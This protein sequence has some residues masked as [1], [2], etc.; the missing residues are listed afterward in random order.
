MERLSPGLTPQDFFEVYKLLVKAELLE[1][2]TLIS[3]SE[4]LERF[5]HDLMIFLNEST[6]YQMKGNDS[7]FPEACVE[8]CNTIVNNTPQLMVEFIDLK[9]I[10]EKVQSRAGGGSHQRVSSGL[11]NIKATSEGQLCGMNVF[12]ERMPEAA[13]LCGDINERIQLRVN[14]ERY[15]QNQ[16]AA[17]IR[18][19]NN[20]Q[21][22]IIAWFQ[23]GTENCGNQ[24]QQNP[25]EKGLRRAWLAINY[26]QSK[27]YAI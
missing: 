19:L 6:E 18:I 15:F 25:K 9:D 14:H 1:N 12:V 27:T 7:M 3:G 20:F 17:M 24:P 2:T 21:R 10:Y 26:L 16:I 4:I 8:Y 13:T 5:S 11:I 23:S 22:K